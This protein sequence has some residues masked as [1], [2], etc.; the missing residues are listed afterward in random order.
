MSFRN[1]FRIVIYLV[2]IAGLLLLGIEAFLNFYFGKKLINTLTTGV[3]EST[4]GRYEL[5]IERAGISLFSRSVTL[6]NL[7]LSPKT[8]DN[9]SYSRTAFTAE[10]FRIN[11]ISLFSLIAKNELEAKD[12]KLDRANISIYQS[13]FKEGDDSAIGKR[14][15]IYLLMKDKIKSVSISSIK[16][17]DVGISVN[18][19]GLTP[20]EI[21][22]SRQNNIEIENLLINQKVDSL[23]RLFFA[24]K[25]QLKMHSIDYILNDLYLLSGKNLICSYEDSVM[26]VDSLKLI[27]HYKKR[28]FGEAAGKQMARV[29]LAANR[30]K[31]R[32]MNV[33]FFLEHNC[34][35]SKI[36]EITGLNINVNLDKNT[37]F[38]PTQKPSLQRVIRNIPF[39]LKVDSVYIKNSNVVYEHLAQQG[40]K[41]GIISFNEING[42]ITG[43]NNSDTLLKSK[44]VLVF[45]ARTRFVNKADMQLSYSFPMNTDKE[46]FDCSGNLKPM[47]MR[48]INPMLE[49]VANM[50]IESGQLDTLT[51]S[52][53]ANELTASGNMKMFYHDL[54]IKMLNKNG[55]GNIGRKIMFLFAKTFIINKE[56]PDKRGKPGVTSIYYERYPYKYFFYYTWKSLQSGLMSAIGLRS[57]FL[58]KRTDS[59]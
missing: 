1:S 11:G 13:V 9:C 57:Q 54:S 51:F 48:D 56:N 15:S 31:F 52:F 6:Y 3:Q 14:L 46:V 4:E 32:Q 2:I 17:K 55:G 28:D 29:Q 5:K 7:K 8:C 42:N 43:L 18:N 34:L 19:S 16:I 21:L 37:D 33:K 50:S 40:K 41:P 49:N 22:K 39:L 44:N 27:P 53:H 35:I 59:E 26:S 24:E 30:V 10:R 25:L 36:A 12:I 58:L 38:K 45:N 20:V 23:N 47:N